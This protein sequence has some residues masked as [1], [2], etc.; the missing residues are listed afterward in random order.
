MHVD[1]P[2]GVSASDGGRRV[3]PSS[4]HVGAYV[5]VSGYEEPSRAIRA[6]SLA[7]MHPVVDIHGSLTWK[8]GVATVRTSTGQTYTLRF[9][10]SSSVRSSVTGIAL[11][12]SDI[13]T[14]SSVHARGIAGSDGTIAVTALT[15]RLRSVTLRAT[16]SAM[17]PKS[18]TVGGQSVRLQPTT[19]FEQGSKTIAPTD[20]VVGD[21]VTVY[22]YRLGPT[23]ILSRKILLH[24]RLLGIDGT[25]ASI[26][27]NA[28]SLSAADGTH[29]VLVGPT[30]IVSG[31]AGTVLAAGMK[32]HVTGYLRGD[33]VLLATRLRLTLVKA[34]VSPTP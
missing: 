20:L 5:H 2:P 6:T 25:V 3:A 24:R 34:V 15:V 31:P 4:L 18:L 8:G 21:D 9:A 14:G 1:V 11:K 28:F 7:V 19:V 33:G 29:Q 23:T 30:T 26:D 22:G 17:D 27:G 12:P 32:V 16:I 13:P 10:P